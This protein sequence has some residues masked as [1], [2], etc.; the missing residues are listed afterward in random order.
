[1]KKKIILMSL[2]LIIFINVSFVSA[3]ELYDNRFLIENYNIISCLSITN[4]SYECVIKNIETNSYYGD[5]DNLSIDILD[6]SSYSFKSTSSGRMQGINLIING[7]EYKSI[8]FFDL[9]PVELVLGNAEKQNLTSGSEMVS[10]LILVHRNS[11]PSSDKTFFIGKMYFSF[12]ASG[13]NKFIDI[14]GIIARDDNNSVEK[15]DGRISV[16]ESWKQTIQT[17]ITNILQS[18]ALIFTK[19]DNY[20]NSSN[21]TNPDYFKYLSSSDRQSIVCGYAKDKHLTNYSDLGWNCNVT[22]RYSAGK[23]YAS[24][25]CKKV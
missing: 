7:E 3:L 20:I 17:T 12:G 8:S 23:E 19:I 5:Y 16:L 15:L 14:S 24:C 1:M 25:R 4:I 10:N 2:L 9:E 22:Y 21:S 6:F 13:A 18:I 11:Y